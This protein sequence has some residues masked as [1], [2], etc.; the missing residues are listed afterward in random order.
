MLRKETWRPRL[1]DHLLH[2]AFA[3]SL[4]GF[5]V[6]VAHWIH[7]RGWSSCRKIL[8]KGGG[9]IFII[10]PIERFSWCIYVFSFDQGYQFLNAP[11]K[12]SCIWECNLW[13]ATR[14]NFKY[15][16]NYYI[17][18]LGWLMGITHS[19]V[20]SFICFLN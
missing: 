11:K 13:I 17:A 2:K 16:G 9:L 8:S 10:C 14:H 3:Y 1:L 4:K 6:Q 7:G 15:K 19:I 12:P 20:L 18:W 5:Q